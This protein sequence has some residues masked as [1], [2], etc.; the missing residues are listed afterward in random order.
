MSWILCN[1]IHTLEKFLLELGLGNL[2]LD[3][4]INLLVVAALVVGVVFDGGREECV[5]EG[6]LSE[7]RLASN[8]VRLDN[9]VY[10]RSSSGHTMIVK[11]APRFAT[12]LCL[13]KCQ[14]VLH[15][16]QRAHYLWLGN[17]DRPLAVYY[18]I[19]SGCTHIGNANW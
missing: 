9:E 14:A 5:D 2:N 11:A 4:F 16:R 19:P 10:G 1:H 8:L 17:Y 12:I 6:R 15:V 7:A 3:S 18:F 13:V